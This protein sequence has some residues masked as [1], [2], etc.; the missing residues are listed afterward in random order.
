M[1]EDKTMP[2]TYRV[3][4]AHRCPD[5][6][7][8]IVRKGDRLRFERRETEWAGWIW[9]TDSSGKRAW[10]PENWV[11]IEGDSCVMKRDYNA[12]ELS[13][14]VGEALTVEFEESGRA[15]VTKD[16]GESG[17]VPSEHLDTDI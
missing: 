14:E 10:V 2:E 17:W 13:V 1:P 4:K 8:L 16:S 11:E 5:P 6:D 7:P 12:I 3:I 9:C 15:W